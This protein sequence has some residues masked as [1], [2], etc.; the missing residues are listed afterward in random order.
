[1]RNNFNRFTI[2]AQEA[3]QNGQEMAASKNNGEFKALHL[4]LALIS[5]GQSLVQP[6]IEK[7]GASLEQIDKSV[8]EELKSFQILSRLRRLQIFLNYIFPRN[9]FRSWKKR[10]SLHWCKKMSLFP[11][12]IYLWVF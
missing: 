4:L 11:A 5:D 2:K 3:L 6:I 8:E 9:L 10:P 7:S 1:M 12:S